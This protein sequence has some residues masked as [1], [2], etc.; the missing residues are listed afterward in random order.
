MLRT[1]LT[2]GL[3]VAA[4]A[5]PGSAGAASTSGIVDVTTNLA[6]ENGAAAG[7]GMTLTSSGEVLTNNHVIRGATTIRV[8]DP[9]TGRRYTATVVGYSVASDVA[10]LRLAGASRLPT[11][12]LGDSSSLKVGQRVTAVGNAGGRGGTPSSVSGSVT[13]LGRTIVASDGQGLQEQLV[14]LIRTDA[15]IR[16]GDSGG[17]LLDAAGRVIGMDTA[18][19]AGFFFQSSSEGYA[20]PI[21]RALALAKQIVAGRGSATVHIG[22]T[23]FLGVRVEPAG[24]GASVVSVV[25]GSPADRAGI[26]AGDTIVALDGR[27]IPSYD[28]LSTLVLRHHAGD[29]VAVRW[30]DQFGTTQSASVRTA[31][32]PPQ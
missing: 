1:A 18:A 8:T 2:A 26:V 28:A 27:L 10:V 23:P 9:S 19:S 16:P 31:V 4:L 7:T 17:P 12:S 6:Y 29:T 30:I 24:S 13:G 20:I 11:V 32:G 14:G 5:V 25:S 22:S 21:N 3:V 15:A